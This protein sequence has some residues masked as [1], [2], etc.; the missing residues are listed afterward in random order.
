M[1][2]HARRRRTE[3][4]RVALRWLAG[5]AAMVLAASA[6]GFLLPVEHIRTTRTV[7]DRPPEAVWRVLIDLDGMPLWRS[8]ITAVT[9]LPDFEGRPTW[10]EEGRHGTRTLELAQVEPLHRLVIQQTR[11]GR[12]VLPVRTFELESTRE[13]TLV[14]ATERN[15]T[16]NPIVRVLARLN[17]DGAPLERFLRDL[18]L[19]VT[20]G[21]RQVATGAG[22]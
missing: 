1:N 5:A 16:R 3:R 9:R 15:A 2:W 19:R 20:A 21:R 14:V 13:G 4:R 17:L 8:D 10:R 12:A 11:A 22:F 6:V 7:V 18:E